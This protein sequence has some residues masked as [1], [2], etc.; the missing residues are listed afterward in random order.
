MGAEPAR[1]T[2]KNQRNELNRAEKKRKKTTGLRS[3]RAAKKL[4]KTNPNRV[5]QVGVNSFY[6]ACTKALSG[7]LIEI[8]HSTKWQ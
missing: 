6:R 2:K 3:G 8:E 1:E 7:S 4:P 5:L